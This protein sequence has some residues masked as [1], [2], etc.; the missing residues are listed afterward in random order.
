[1]DNRNIRKISKR[2]MIL[3]LTIL[4]EMMRDLKFA[5]LQI[6]IFKS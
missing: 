6:N 4:V 3:T 2:G 5:M 1:M